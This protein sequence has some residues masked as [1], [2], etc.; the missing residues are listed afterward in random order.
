MSCPTVAVYAYIQTFM[1]E[2]AGVCVFCVQDASRHK[3]DA[4]A[5]ASKAFVLDKKTKSWAVKERWE[6][7]VGDFVK[8]MKDFVLAGKNT[9]AVT[10]YSTPPMW[11]NALQSFSMPTFSQPGKTW[12][13]YS[14]IFFFVLSGNRLFSV[15]ISLFFPYYYLFIYLFRHVLFIFIYC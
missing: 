10:S 6:V 12:R 4:I 5:N 11:G 14:Y 7:A 2:R 1:C 9:T 13:E 3:A 8:V 15:N